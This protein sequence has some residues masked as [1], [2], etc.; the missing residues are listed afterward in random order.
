M[1]ENGPESDKGTIIVRMLDR[2][3]TRLESSTQARRPRLLTMAETAD[4]L[5]VSIDTVKR[6]CD[7]REL[8]Y[9]Q[10]RPNAAKRIAEDELSRWITAHSVLPT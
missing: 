4:C 2:I 9:V 10:A 1:I 7:R 6:M 3:L 8:A 5:G